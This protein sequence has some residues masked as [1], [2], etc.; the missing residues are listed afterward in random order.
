MF[1]VFQI[2]SL[3]GSLTKKNPNFL[4][5]PSHWRII[6]P[7]DSEFIK[8]KNGCLVLLGEDGEVIKEAQQIIYPTEMLEQ[9]I[10]QVKKKAIPVFKEAHPSCQALFIFYQSSAHAALPP[11]ADMFARLWV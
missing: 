6:H 7:S 3:S 10:E 11:D 8:P 1:T 9:V 4:S 2:I 5:Q